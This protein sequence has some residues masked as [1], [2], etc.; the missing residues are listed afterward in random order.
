MADETRTTGG[1]RCI[2]L[3]GTVASGK[4]TVGKRLSD[5]TGLPLFHNHLVVDAVLSVFPF[6][7][8]AFVRL[9]DQLWMDV[10]REAAAAGRS[11]IFTFQPEPSV[12]ADFPSRL[13]AT[14][15]KSGG[16]V[17]FVRLTVSDELQ[18]L[19]IANANRNQWR[20]LTSIELLRELKPEF[21]A[22]EAR[23]PQ[24]LLTIDTGAHGAGESSAKIIE[25]LKLG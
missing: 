2:F 10:F 11:L 20:K 14:F 21:D 12:A 4:L 19:R 6:G 18:E 24:P 7:D 9:R 17:D 15:A 1:P 13:Q 23:M 25:A 22:C 16:R 8:P 3:Y 5:M